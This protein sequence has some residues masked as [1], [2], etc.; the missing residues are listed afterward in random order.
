MYFNAFVLRVLFDRNYDV[1]TQSFP[2][3]NN[4]DIFVDIPLAIVDEATF[5]SM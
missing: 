2:L 4:Y 1:K 5:F 3:D